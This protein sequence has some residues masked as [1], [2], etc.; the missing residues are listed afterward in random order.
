M[1]WKSSTLDGLEG[2]WQLCTVGYPSD[3]VLQLQTYYSR[4]LSD[5]SVCSY[6]K[7]YLFVGNK[8]LK[9]GLH[10]TDVVE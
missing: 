2:H 4:E 7:T 5:D 1:K 9:L 10:L 6:L 8:K 3:S